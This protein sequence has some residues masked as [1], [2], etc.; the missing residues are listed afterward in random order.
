M[1]DKIDNITLAFAGIL[2]SV[3]LVQEISQT[4]KIDNQPAFEAS[5]NSIF[6]TDP[7]D[8]PSVYG[9]LSGIQLGLEKLLSVFDTRQVIDRSFSRCMMSLI[10][11]QKKVFQSPR[12]VEILAQR[13]QQAKK[14]VDYFSLTHPTVIGSLADIYLSTISTFKLKILILSSQRILDVKENMDKIRA[15][16]LAGIR[17]AVLWRQYGGSRL[18]LIFSRDKM[19]VAANKLL[20]RI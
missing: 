16:L 3:C 7:K 17:S 20:E 11:L 5:I 13:V 19:R 14:Q 1:L 12:L 2:Q 18:Q 15:I 9:N 10:H 6:Q 4:G 8:G